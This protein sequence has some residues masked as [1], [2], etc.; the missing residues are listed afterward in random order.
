MGRVVP[1]EIIDKKAGIT[2]KCSAELSVGRAHLHGVVIIGFNDIGVHIAVSPETAL[3][4]ADHLGK[5]AKQLLAAERTP[6]S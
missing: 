6:R 3:E 5:E 4:L 1:R 2:A